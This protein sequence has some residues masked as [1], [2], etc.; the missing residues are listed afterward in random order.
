MPYS[1]DTSAGFTKVTYSGTLDNKDI[2][3][4]LREELKTDDQ[5]LKMTNRLEDMKKLKGIKIGFE[6]LMG[7]T[8]SILT[9][10][11]SQNVKT[12]ILTGNPLQYGIARMFQSILEHPQMKIQIFSDEEEAHKWLVKIE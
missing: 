3:G 7:F 1:I 6:D 2:Q 9:I 4:V 5:E 8:D 10:Q 12:A 11:L